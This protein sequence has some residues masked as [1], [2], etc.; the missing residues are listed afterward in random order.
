[1][2]VFPRDLQRIVAPD[3]A[4]AGTDEVHRQIE[5]HHFVDLLRHQRRKR[6]ENVGV[7]LGRFFKKFGGFDQIVKHVLGG[8]M[9]AE[10]VVGKQDRVAGEVLHHGIR[11]VQHHGFDENQFLS[12]Q[13]E[14]VAGFHHLEVPVLVIVALEGFQS[15]GCAVHGLTGNPVHQERQGAGVV[16]F[17]VVGNHVVDFVE[18][19]FFGKIVHEF[20][21]E[22][23]PDR[24]NESGLFISHQV[25]VVR[26]AAMRRVFLSVKLAQLPVNL[27]YPIHTR[28]NLE[29]HKTPPAFYL[30]MTSSI[31]KRVTAL[32]ACG[33]CA[34][35]RI[36]SPSPTA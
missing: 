11:P 17:R 36:I 18:V 29:F 4:V 2:Q 27:P 1:M 23:R 3:D 9:L 22:R 26:R 24:V 13:A 5:P 15:V 28:C 30:I 16:H 10:G 6:R 12:A 35:I 20:F 7:I 21:C 25:R 19:D 14:L 31:L 34:G 8:N 33:L 32:S